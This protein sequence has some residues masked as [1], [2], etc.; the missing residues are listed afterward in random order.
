MPNNNIEPYD[1]LG[2][3]RHAPTRS[4]LRHSRIMSHKQTRMLPRDGD[5]CAG[6]DTRWVWLGV[7][8]LLLASINILATVTLMA[9]INFQSQ[10]NW[11]FYS[12]PW[13]SFYCDH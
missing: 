4:S 7:S 12:G 1:I 8:Q 6:G 13:V 3:F 11:T 5:T 2:M 10:Y 9:A